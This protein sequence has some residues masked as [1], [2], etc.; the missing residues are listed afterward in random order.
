[1]ITREMYEV[2]ELYILTLYNGFLNQNFLQICLHNKRIYVSC[3]YLLQFLS[4]ENQGFSSR[5]VENSPPPMKDKT[6]QNCDSRKSFLS[7]ICKGSAESQ[8]LSVAFTYRV[9]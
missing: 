8:D 2:L 3:N 4:E 1:M 9:F 5:N 7:K 6:K